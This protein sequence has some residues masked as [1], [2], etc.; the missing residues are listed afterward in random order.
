MIDRVSREVTKA[1]RSRVVDKSPL[2][3]VR[4]GLAFSATFDDGLTMNG[5][6]IAAARNRAGAGDLAQ[7]VGV[8]Q[9][10]LAPFVRGARPAARFDG[11]NDILVGSSLTTAIAVPYDFFAVARITTN[12][13]FGRIMGLAGTDN[14]GLDCNAAGEIYLFNGSVANFGTND[15]LWHVFYGRFSGASSRASIDRG[16]VIESLNP[17]TSASSLTGVSVGGANAGITKLA[18]DVGEVHVFNRTLSDVERVACREAL[19][20]RWGLP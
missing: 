5:L 11:S 16:R 19:M 20:A 1:D 14:L 3:P 9:P 12:R 10:L 6:A 18:G 8:S 13:N 4:R 15:G 2:L 7:G 17:G